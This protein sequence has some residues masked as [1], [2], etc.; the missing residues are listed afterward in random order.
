MAKRT[1]KMALVGGGMFGR[2]VVLRSLADIEQYGIT[3]YLATAGLD[4]RARSLADIEY[5]LVAIGT[6]TAKTGESLSREYIKW[7]PARAGAPPAPVDGESPWKE[8]LSKH[9]PDV[10]FVATP[11]HLHTAPI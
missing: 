3:P 2:D 4:H 11:D 6:R 7:V 10:L 5:Q 8:I 1:L 9:K